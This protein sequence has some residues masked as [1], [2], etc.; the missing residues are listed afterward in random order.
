MVIIDADSVPHAL[1]ACVPGANLSPRARLW[2]FLLQART[3]S[4]HPDFGS[5]PP[6]RGSGP[7][8]FCGHV[9]KV[10]ARKAILYLECIASGGPVPRTR[11]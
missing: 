6:A 10:R 9:P 5:H 7:R 1:S 11:G 4:G 8:I 3:M 2:T